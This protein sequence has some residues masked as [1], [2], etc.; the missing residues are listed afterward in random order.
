MFKVT[1]RTRQRNMR[2]KTQREEQICKGRQVIQHIGSHSGRINSAWEISELDDLVRKG[3]SGVSSRE[4]T[5]GQNS[6]Y[7]SSEIGTE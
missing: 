1:P 5:T 4:S 6:T 7:V 3:L 2:L